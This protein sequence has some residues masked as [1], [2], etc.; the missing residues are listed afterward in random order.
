MKTRLR[1][2]TFAA[3]FPALFAALAAAALAPVSA[4]DPTKP[5]PWRGFVHAAA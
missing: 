4:P 3:L 2:F 1:S 5:V